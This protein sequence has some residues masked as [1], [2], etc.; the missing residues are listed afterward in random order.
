[1]SKYIRKKLL[2]GKKCHWSFQWQK[3]QET[4]P[5]TKP[6]EDLDKGRFWR[7]IKIN[8]PF[9]LEQVE[10]LGKEARRQQSHVGTGL[11][12]SLLL[13]IQWRT[14]SSPGQEPVPGSVSSLV[15][16]SSLCSYPITS[17]FFSYPLFAL[18]SLQM[19]LFPSLFFLFISFYSF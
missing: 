7:H 6:K 12:L 16:R 5:V 4:R 10:P 9:S 3:K 18:I 2:L 13:A 11:S 1:M 8:F 14:K 15:S 19:L 17:S